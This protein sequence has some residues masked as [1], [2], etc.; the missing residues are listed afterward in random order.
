ML[1]STRTLLP[2]LIAASLASCGSSAEPPTDSPSTRQ[3]APAP[4]T[5]GIGSPATP[6]PVPPPP[7]A[8]APDAVAARVGEHE[9]LE[10]DLEAGIVRFVTTQT[11]GRP[12]PPAQMNQA[13]ASLR[14][15]V[16]DAL[17]DDYLLDEDA[18]EAGIEETT[19]EV[20][21]ELERN[22]ANHLRQADLERAELE[23]RVLA[24]EGIGLDEFVRRQAEDEAIRRTMRHTKLLE[25]TYADRVAVTNEEIAAS[26]EENLER[27]YTRP[28]TVRASHILIG[29]Q[30]L[31]SP[32]ERTAAREKAEALVVEA[33][34][35]EADFAQLARD[36]STG[37]SA[38][39][40]GDLGWFPRQGAMVE[41]FAAA[42]FALETGAVSDVVETRFGYHVI[43][44]D[45]R[46][47]GGTLP[48]D[49]VSASIRGSLRGQ[50]LAELR[51][52]HVK[53]LRE[54]AEIEIA[55]GV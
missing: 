34:A 54:N 9:I 37:P 21:A 47:E 41:P 23:E 1:Q 25:E 48:L 20:I 10:A 22:L 11:Q 12:L 5:A 35:P 39:Q 43:R 33:R 26:Y 44:C 14:G 2:A 30:Q 46:K 38:P 55:A 50:K 7:P 51:A 19:E 42:A 15:Q 40:G 4:P 13:R 16:L 27:A 36:N 6:T 17:I 18:A 53:T 29:T 28:E 3:P 31:T 8:R 45:D 52:E 32:E 24:A 49:E